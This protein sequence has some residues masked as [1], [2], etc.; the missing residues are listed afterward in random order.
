MFAA[1]LGISSGLSSYYI[2]H[3]HSDHFKETVFHRSV[4]T[5]SSIKDKINYVIGS[6]QSTAPLP[7]VEIQDVKLIHPDRIINFPIKDYPTLNWS[8]LNDKTLIHVVFYYLNKPYR[9]VFSHGQNFKVLIDDLKWLEDGFHNAIDQVESNLESEDV[10]EV[11]EQYAGPLGD[12]YDEA[13]IVPMNITGF[14]NKDMSQRLN[15]LASSDPL[16]EGYNRK[17]FIKITDILGETKLF[18]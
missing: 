2:Y 1:L 9:I 4:E 11:L 13:D 8:R 5:Y 3:Y 15:Y 17:P 12:F 18:S 10:K 7:Q 16:S 6:N 14:L